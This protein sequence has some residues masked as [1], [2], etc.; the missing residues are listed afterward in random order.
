MSMDGKI[1]DVIRLDKGIPH[2]G[3]IFRNK[4]TY[5]TVNGKIIKIDSDNLS[6]MKV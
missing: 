4:F 5:T 6:K 1:L 2:D 3:L